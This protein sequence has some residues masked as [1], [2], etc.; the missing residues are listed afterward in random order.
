MG[1]SQRNR[2]VSMTEVNLIPMMDVLMAV[3]TFFI[4]ISMTLST[5]QNVIGVNLPRT[6]D[7]AKPSAQ[8]AKA[9]EPLMVGMNKQ[10]QIILQNKPVEPSQLDTQ[11]Q[12]YFQKSPQGVVVFQADKTLT[13]E[14]LAKVLGQ[15]REIGGDRVALAV[16]VQ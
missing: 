3:L 16:D 5:G 4:V 11:L 8:D 10:G 9:P 6:D 2:P 7:G 14:K 1:Y 15:I 12:A 13:Y